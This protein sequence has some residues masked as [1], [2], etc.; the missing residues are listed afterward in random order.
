MKFS[1]TIWRSILFVRS[2]SFILLTSKN[3]L[4][5]SPWDI[6]LEEFEDSRANHDK[7]GR[8]P[9]LPAWWNDVYLIY[10]M[11]TC[12]MGGVR[13]RRYLCEKDVK[14]RR[15]IG[16]QNARSKNTHTK[17]IL[18]PHRSMLLLLKKIS[19]FKERVI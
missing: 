12:L 3:I 5:T 6:K 9:C 16:W 4:H 15:Q 10:F 7:D 1:T 18:I 8:L 13:K 19:M 11:A 17:Y 14:F 2:M